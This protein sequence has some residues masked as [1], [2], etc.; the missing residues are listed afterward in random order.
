LRRVCAN[1]VG[2][3]EEAARDGDTAVTAAALARARDA[4]A[5]AELHLE[6]TQRRAQA[7]EAARVE[8]VRDAVRGD[9][10][11][12]VATQ[13]LQMTYTAAVEQLHHL[14]T[15]LERYATTRNESI[16]QA[17]AV[18]ILAEAD[19]NPPLPIETVLTFAINEARGRPAAAM[20]F[21]NVTRVQRHELLSPEAADAW[22][23]RFAVVAAAQ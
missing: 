8:A 2:A 13:L 21:D 10:I 5:L 3:L 4:A 19:V 7:E 11:Q 20:W 12:P 22:D 18:G 14:T 15:Q 6:A 23:T 16:V 17:R 9:H 1:E